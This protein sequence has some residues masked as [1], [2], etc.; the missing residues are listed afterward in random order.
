MKK[1][2]VM[3]LS[4]LL[5]LLVGQAAF[6]KSISLLVG[7]DNTSRDYIHNISG[8]Y[9]DD[10]TKS[11]MIGLSGE[12]ELM[13]KLALSASATMITGKYVFN[14][15]NTNGTAKLFQLSIMLYAKYDLFKQ[16]NTS[17]GLQAGIIGTSQNRKY[18]TYTVQGGALSIGAG[19]YANIGITPKFNLYADAKFPLYTI[20]KDITTEYTDY[21]DRIGLAKMFLYDVTVGISYDIT[22]SISLGIEG[23]INNFSYLKLSTFNLPLDKFSN[24]SVGVKLTYKF[25]QSA[26]VTYQGYSNPYYWDQQL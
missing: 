16:N 23:A 4:L 19:L 2:F 10:L 1:T 22:S 8:P 14:E 17:F 20:S 24:F 12:Y 5:V 11:L 13:D 18:A 7:Y 3:I 26:P 15:N 21:E 6:A 9:G 25:G